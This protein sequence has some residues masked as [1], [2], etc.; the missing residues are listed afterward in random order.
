VQLIEK[1]QSRRARDLVEDHYRAILRG[2]RIDD[3]PRPAFPLE[4]AFAREAA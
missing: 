4:A 3:R 2:F 1:R